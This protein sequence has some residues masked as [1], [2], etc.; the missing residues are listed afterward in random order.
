M[1]KSNRIHL[2]G[3]FVVQSEGCMLYL[4]KGDKKGAACSLAKPG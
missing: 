2:L 4:E 3:L 1:E